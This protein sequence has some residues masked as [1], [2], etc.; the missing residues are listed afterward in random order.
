M[1][2]C[3]HP[4]YED[5]LQHTAG[6]NGSVRVYRFIIPLHTQRLMGPLKNQ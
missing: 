6:V 1:S 3:P 2:L 4:P 5:T